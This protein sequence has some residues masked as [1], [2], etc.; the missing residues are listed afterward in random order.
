MI[1]FIAYQLGLMQGW[2]EKK[3]PTQQSNNGGQEFFNL[4]VFYLLQM[5]SFL[6]NLVTKTRTC[7][8]FY[9]W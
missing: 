4:M 8:R 3:A 1:G 7:L 5:K 9:Y 6:Y 2:E